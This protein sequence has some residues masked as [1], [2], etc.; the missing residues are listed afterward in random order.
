MVL[1][2]LWALGVL[3]PLNC[4]LTTQNSRLASCAFLF[5]EKQTRFTFWSQ[6]KR[7]R[8]LSVEIWWRKVVRRGRKLCIKVTRLIPG[9]RNQLFERMTQC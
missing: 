2:Q 9:K 5:Q 6:C 4:A 7:K 1:W 3:L 8:N